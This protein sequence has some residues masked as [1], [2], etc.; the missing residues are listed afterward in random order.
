MFDA[1]NVLTIQSQ[2]LVF[3]LNLYITFQIQLLNFYFIQ[4]HTEQ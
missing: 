2:L 3:F 1:A 4:E